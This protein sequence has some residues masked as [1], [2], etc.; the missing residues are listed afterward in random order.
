MAGTAA[1]KGTH[2]RP[3]F[4]IKMK[5]SSYKLSPVNSGL[6]LYALSWIWPLIEMLAK[7]KVMNVYSIYAL[8]KIGLVKLLL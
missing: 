5:I 2:C 7:K 4:S 1:K 8:K 6:L 3:S